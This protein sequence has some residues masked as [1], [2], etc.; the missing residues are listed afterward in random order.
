MPHAE[1]PKDSWSGLKNA[2]DTMETATSTAATRS[3]RRPCRPRSACVWTL[4][5]AGGAF[6]SS[7]DEAH[8]IR[9]AAERARVER[10]VAE[11]PELT[12]PA[13]DRARAKLDADTFRRLEEVVASAYAE[14]RLRD[15]LVAGIRLG[16]DAA[17]ADRFLAWYD[18]PLG[19]DLV[20]DAR[21]SGTPE[22][23]RLQP[24]FLADFMRD[25]TARARREVLV[26]LDDAM[27]LSENVMRVA[28][29]ISTGFATGALALDCVPAAEWPLRVTI[30]AAEVERRR[31]AATGRVRFELEF[32]YRARSTAELAHY[33]R[34]AESDDARWIY[35]AFHEQLQKALGEASTD[36]QQRIAPM[37]S[38]RCAG[39]PE[40]GNGAGPPARKT[41]S[42]VDD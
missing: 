26:R 37:I 25:P 16:G 3:R 6:A 2:T 7:P 17:R 35:E 9:A 24:L 4:L 28:L 27:H 38:S 33:A 31:A 29:A 22:G 5:I 21:R 14:A 13:R 1:A 39:P 36:L 11:W 41:S 42:D 20:A 30:A 40:A 10:H 18:T 32:T 8:R 34:F 19:R 23:L 12:L 15:A